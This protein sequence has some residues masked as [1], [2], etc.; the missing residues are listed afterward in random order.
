MKFEL[1]EGEILKSD[2]KT[3]CWLVGLRNYFHPSKL[4]EMKTMLG[5]NWNSDL[6]ELSL[7][8]N[9]SNVIAEWF[10]T[11]KSINSSIWNAKH[12]HLILLVC[13]RAGSDNLF[14]ELIK[15]FP[16]VN[17]NENKNE[18]LK[19]IIL[20][21]EFAVKSSF[22]KQVT[23]KF[24]FQNEYDRLEMINFANEKS[25]EYSKLISKLKVEKS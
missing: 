25:P 20:N 9:T 14:S 11:N 17:L 16:N 7:I 22:F 5:I 12:I 3:C 4:E 13:C 18:A 24:V 8:A 15:K 10:L 2:L 21:H 6:L 19:T 23:K 1:N